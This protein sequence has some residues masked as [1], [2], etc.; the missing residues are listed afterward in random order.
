MRWLFLLLVVLNVF[1]Y[2][3]HQQEAPLRAKEVV[4][5]SLYKGSHQ[6]I[7]LLSE[8]QPAG[9]GATAAVDQ[10]QSGECMFLGNLPTEELLHSLQRRLSAM[11]MP[12][13]QVEGE[14]SEIPGYALRISPQG[15]AAA[16]EMVLQNLVNEFN[17]L[18]YKKMR[19]EG[20]QVSDSLHRMAPAP[21]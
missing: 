9:V 8:A 7:R 11:D 3:W 14:Q 10:A 12:S 5:L 18:K 13:V 20:L 19:C 21:Q 2:I 6:G 1:Y 4:S 16:S 17:G 15:T